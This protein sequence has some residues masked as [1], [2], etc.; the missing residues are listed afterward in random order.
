MD[1]LIT[2]AVITLVA[3]V[4]GYLVGTRRLHLPLGG[5]SQETKRLE[6]YPFYPFT[7]NPEGHVEFDAALFTEGIRHLLEHRNERAARELIVIGEQNLVR[8]TF[9]SDTL[10][11][12][13]SFYASYH[14]D[15]VVNENEAYL[16]NYRRLVNQIGRS[17]RN[18][19]IEIL[20]HN[21][22]NPSRSLVAIENGE[23]T[24]RSIG[25]GAT[26]L[27]L[28]LKTRRQRGEDK[29]NY[30]LNIG[31]RR[32]K[33]T[34]VPIFRPDY[35][36]VGAICINFD[37]NFI[38]D[39]ASDPDRVNA[40]IDNLLRTDFQLDENILSKDEYQLAVRGKRH[41]MDDAIRAPSVRTQAR[42]LV[43]ILFSDIVDFAKLMSE[44]EISTLHIM[45]ANE[46]IHLRA[47]ASH[48]GLLLKKLGDGI[49][50]SFA[51][52]SGA[53]ECALEVQRAVALDG[54]YQVRVG[55]HLGEV[56]EADG[57][58]HGDG[59]NIASRIQNAV[60]PG[61][62]GVS[63]VVYDNVRNKGGFSATPLGERSLKG[64]DNPMMLYSLDAELA[65]LDSG[66]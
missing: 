56:V 34:T 18:T 33:C 9:P 30:E 29:V 47:L 31:S 37:A 8:D 59:V 64:V 2:A 7:I 61:Q 1:P 27:V 58:V 5:D 11:E 28:D 54:R 26:N 48:G 36:L 49:L 23:V 6:E 57:D 13:K 60:E 65:P 50:A 25:A 3:G 66:D 45:R 46:E 40:F 51:T 24:G 63:K 39:A 55:I 10:A 41:F 16:E 20:L 4:L 62:I 15:E 43:A 35:G 12:Y 22:V 14:G 17:I 38:R 53:V 21:L 52:A 44:H 32:F 19:G 42:K